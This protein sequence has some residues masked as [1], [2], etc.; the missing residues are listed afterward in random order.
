MKK[1]LI[2]CLA[3]GL[4]FTSGNTASA[5]KP[6]GNKETLMNVIVKGADLHLSRQG[7]F[8]VDNCWEWVIGSGSSGMNVQGISATGLLAAYE[9][10]GDVM[11]LDGAMA[12][13]DTL[14]ERYEADPGKR[15]FSQDVEFLVRLSQDSG[16]PLYYATAVVW[17]ANVIDS[18]SADEIVDRYITIRGGSM[19]GWDLASQIR[20]ASLVGEREY[21]IGI[22]DELIERADEWVGVESYGWDYTTISYG[23][24]LWAL[25]QI[26]GYHSTIAS[27][28]EFLVTSQADDGSW[29]GGDYQTVAYV[30]L[31][32]S[33]VNGKDSKD[34]LTLAGS[35]LITTQ[36]D[37]GGWEYEGYGEYGEVNSEA[38]MALGDLK[39]NEGLHK[40][41]Y[42]VKNSHEFKA[43][44]V[45]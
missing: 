20:A 7:F 13:G 41:K 4:V 35:F 42:R 40:G 3:A 43:F 37:D 25:H 29:D 30:M 22:T 45:R 32:L 18:L 16:D 38:L 27:C 12:A 36:T 6:G 15:P 26:G 14:V 24:L 1:V 44:P 34:A 33:Q 9:R 5:A 17:Y 2:L 19:A 11:Y 31:G 39:V 21:A 23:S 28:R 10:T 8:G